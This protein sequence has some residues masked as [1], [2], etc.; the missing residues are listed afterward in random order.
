[1]DNIVLYSES[2]QFIKVVVSITIG[3]K[4]ENPQLKKMENAFNIFDMNQDG[5]V[6]VNEFEEATLRLVDH[7]DTVANWKDILG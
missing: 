7:F 4:F 5:F 2:S 6:S 1:M 3:L